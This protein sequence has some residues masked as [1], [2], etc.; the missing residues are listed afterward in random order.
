MRHNLFIVGY[1]SIISEDDR[2]VATCYFDIAI[3][4]SD[5][6]QHLDYLQSQGHTFI[7]FSEIKGAIENKAYKPTIIY[8]DDGFSDN[9]TVALPILESRNIKATVFVTTGF[10]DGTE[11]PQTSYLRWLLIRQAKESKEIEQCVQSFKTKSYDERRIL[12]DKYDQL[13]PTAKSDWEN[14]SIYLTKDQLKLLVSHDIEIGS[15]TAS[16]TKLTELTDSELDIELRQSREVLRVLTAQSIE[17]LSFPH[18]RSDERVVNTLKN[19]GYTY[20]VGTDIGINTARSIVRNPWG[21]K[22][23]APKPQ[24][25]ITDFAWRMYGQSLFS[26]IW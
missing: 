12:T 9:L 18:G 7:H 23:I 11:I 22:K 2:G 20:A 24:E 8:F 4:A 1:H 21:L 6:T 3:S 25:S 17:V 19:N 15:H 26:K 13:D 10:I 5:F 14:L 16:H